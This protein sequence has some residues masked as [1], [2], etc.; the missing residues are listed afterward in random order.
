[1]V[2][3]PFFDSPRE[4]YFNF[5]RRFQNVEFRASALVSFRSVIVSHVY[6]CQ[7]QIERNKIDY[8]LKYLNSR[9]ARSISPTSEWPKKKTS[10]A[11]GCIT[12]LDT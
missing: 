5:P 11:I 9:E 2:T 3:V 12:S 4:L 10:R 8:F 1:M 6:T 7:T